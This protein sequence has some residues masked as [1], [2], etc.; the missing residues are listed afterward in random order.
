MRKKHA[1]QAQRS[2]KIVYLP[3][4]IGCASL[5]VRTWSELEE[6]EDQRN[7]LREGGIPAP[8][9]ISLLSGTSANR[10]QGMIGTPIVRH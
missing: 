7:D 4:G 5:G 8:T 2:I 9:L 6:S 3:D 10:Y 1:V